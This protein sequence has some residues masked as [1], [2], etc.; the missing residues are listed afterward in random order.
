LKLNLAMDASVNDR[1]NY[2]VESGS[3]IMASPTDAVTSL[4]LMKKFQLKRI[5]KMQ[6]FLYY[7][8]LIGKKKVSDDLE[9]KYLNKGG[10]LNID[11]TGNKMVVT[12]QDSNGRY[13][14]DWAFDG[15]REDLKGVVRRFV[16][17]VIEGIPEE[18]RGLFPSY[19]QEVLN[20][21]LKSSE[22]RWEQVLKRY[23]GMIPIPS[24]KTKMRLNRREPLRFDLPG[25]M[26][27]HTV[28]LVVAIDTSGSMSDKMLEKVFVEIFEILKKKKYELTVI[29][30][31][32]E[33][34]RVY[35]AKKIGDI[36]MKV[37]GRGGTCFTPVIDYVNQNIKLRDSVFVY[38]TD[39]YGEEKI[40]RPKTY[41]NLWVIIGKK[42]NL[43]VRNPYGEV[44]EISHD[45]YEDY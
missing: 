13:C 22:I 16:L 39:G 24:R 44:L 5:E 11:E 34:G 14:H 12:I 3:N 36:E 32:S 38:F 21:I 1:L 35:Q 31:D 15:L 41:R 23:I 20:R 33:I 42:E 27:E 26:N 2:E 6:S 40:P 37:T 18:S 28:R 25:R 4:V 9:K 45:Y 43:S 7:Y 19:Q 17:D 30:C 29:E 10:C 8:Q